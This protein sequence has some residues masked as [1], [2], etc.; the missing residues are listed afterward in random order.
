MCWVK[1]TRYFRLYVMKNLVCYLAIVQL[2]LK[3]FFQDFLRYPGGCFSPPSTPYTCYFPVN[4]IRMKGGATDLK[5]R[6]FRRLV[7][8]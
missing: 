6:N 1:P 7:V 3:V 4:S 5:E 8:Q 2:N